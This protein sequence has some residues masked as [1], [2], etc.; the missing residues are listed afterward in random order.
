[1]PLFT[2]C[3]NAADTAT[4]TAAG[5]LAGHDVE[6]DTDK[7]RVTIHAKDAQVRIARDGSAMPLPE[8][9]PGDV[10]VPAG[11]EV[12][13]SMQVPRM[14]NVSGKV[15]GALTDVFAEARTA[16]REHGW[17]EKLVTQRPTMQML[18]LEK[19]GREAVINLM[20]REGAVQVSYSLRAPKGQQ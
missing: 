1:M 11:L 4:E 17:R 18:S 8:Q 5:R 7:D 3:Q 13:S 20:E 16:M 12:H 9:F 14:L 6:V 10:F 2:A 19:D 15:P